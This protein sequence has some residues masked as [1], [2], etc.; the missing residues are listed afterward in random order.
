MSSPRLV[1]RILTGLKLLG[2]Q[3]G[4]LC[5]L[6]A[7]VDCPWVVIG[8]FNATI[9]LDDRLGCSSNSPEPA[10]QD[11]VFNCGLHDLGYSGPDFTWYRGNCSVRL[12]HC[13]GNTLWFKNFPHSSLQHL[14]HMKSDHRPIL[15]CSTFQHAYPRSTNFRYFS[16]WSLH[17]EF[18]RLVRDNWDSSIPIMDVVNKFSITVEK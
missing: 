18:K 2:S 12:D 6:V 13:F 4:H 14:L 16:G 7:F 3:G 15:L 1:F 5:S 11:M 17:R 8:D 10:F 9:S